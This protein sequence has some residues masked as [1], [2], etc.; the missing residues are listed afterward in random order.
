[1]ATMILLVL[2][3]AGA[4][5]T[6]IRTVRY[7]IRT[8]RRDLAD[9]LAMGIIALGYVLLWPVVFVRQMVGK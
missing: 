1:M 8:P 9:T 3:L 7:L 2:Y 5:H 4:L 6:G